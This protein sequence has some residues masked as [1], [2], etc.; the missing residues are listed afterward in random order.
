MVIFEHVLR[1]YN[2]IIW[3]E[4]KLYDDIQRG[5]GA[6]AGNEIGSQLGQLAAS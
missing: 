3:L 5:K 4:Y 6:A 1:K 2:R